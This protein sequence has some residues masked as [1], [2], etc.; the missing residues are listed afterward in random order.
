MSLTPSPYIWRFEVSSYTWGR[1]THTPASVPFSSQPARCFWAPRLWTLLSLPPLS[2]CPATQTPYPPSHCPDTDP[3]SA[4][5]RNWWASSAWG[6][7]VPSAHCPTPGLTSQLGHRTCPLQPGLL[8]SRV[9]T[10]HIHHFGV[11]AEHL[12]TRDQVPSGAPFIYKQSLHP[13]TLKCL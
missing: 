7:L 11:H 1:C 10:P 3:S 6:M 2:L 5:E 12:P 8:H 4:S 13:N 9:E